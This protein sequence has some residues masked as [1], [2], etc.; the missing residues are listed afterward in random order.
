MASGN[1]NSITGD[2]MDVLDRLWDIFE[3]VSIKWHVLANRAGFDTTQNAKDH[4]DDIGKFKPG[5]IAITR[6]DLK[7]AMGLADIL[8]GVKASIPNSVVRQQW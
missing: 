6:R 3:S 1:G 8:Y 2:Q 5:K 7:T 4:Y